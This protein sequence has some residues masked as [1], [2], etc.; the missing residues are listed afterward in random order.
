MSGI[1]I[2][3]FI[4][5]LEAVQDKHGDLEVVVD[6]DGVRNPFYEHLDFYIEQEGDGYTEERKQVII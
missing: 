6:R 5:R 1:Q 4:E 2:S 3:E